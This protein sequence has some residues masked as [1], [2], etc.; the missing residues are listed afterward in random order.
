MEIRY[1]ANAG[2][3]YSAAGYQVLADPWILGAPFEG[4]WSHLYP[5]KCKPSDFFGVDLIYISHGH[6]DHYDEETLKE[7]PKTI[8]ILIYDHKV[9]FLHRKLSALGFKH[10]TVMADRETKAF[11]PFEI[12]MFGPF[13]KHP[14][15][16]SEIGN[17]VDSGIIL[18]AGGKTVG[19][20]ND[21]TL[22]PGSACG[23][24]R[25]GPY[26]LL[27]LV[28]SCAG[29]YPSCFTNLTHEEKLSERARILKRHMDMMIEVCKILKPRFVQPFAGAYKLQGPLSELN[30]YLA[31]NEPAETARIYKEAGIESLLLYEGD[32]Y[33]L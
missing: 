12:T 9:N 25:Y 6:S 8:Q 30:Q 33:E 3:L 16:D 5:I 28:D 10:I 15:H 27:Q 19:N 22:T 2:C 26:D 13:V 4:S 21:N 14:F 1:L 11:G 32:S 17:L 20:F 23:L 7:F 18:K 24:I 31:V 29:P